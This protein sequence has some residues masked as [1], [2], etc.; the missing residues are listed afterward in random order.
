MKKALKENKKIKVK[1]DEILF[2][3]IQ[4]Q[5]GITFKESD[6][7]LCGDGYI[8]PLRIY[9]LPK[10]L[11]D[12]WLDDIL[13]IDGTIGAIDISTRDTAEVKKNI[14]KSLKEEFTRKHSAKDYLE[15]YDAT[16]R[17]QE[18]EM[19]L[20]ELSE[21]GETVKM[22]DFRLFIP[23]RRQVEME[24]RAEVIVK[25][26]EGDSYMCS[27]F[28]NEGRR[29][30]EA[31]F[32]P[33][34]KSHAKTFS[35]KGFP[36]LTEQLAYGDPFN[37]SEL[38]DS[39]GDLIGFTS[40]DGAVIFDEFTK[41]ETRKHYNS[42]VVGD[43]GSGK[44]TLLKKRFKS[45]AAKGNFIRTFDI[46][47]EFTEL[48]KEFGGKIIKCNGESGLLN[49]ME[50]L[51]AGDD[52]ATS[53]ARHISKVSTF[54]KAIFPSA[55]DELISSLQNV[56]R[57]F[58]E[59][60]DLLPGRLGGITSL[61]SKS[62]PILSDLLH[63][64]ESEMDNILKAP[65]ETV[66]EKTL[67]EAKIK[68]LYNIENAIKNVV[69]NYGR[70]FDGHTSVDN[71]TDEKIV[72]FDISEIKDL[73]NVFA[74][75]IFNMVSLCWDNAVSNGKIMK[76][77]WEEETAE[78][79][80]IVK[81]LIIIDESHRWVNTKMP[82]ILDLL[83]K[84]LREARK[85][86]AGIIF[87]S[88]SMRDYIP[89]G[90]DAPNVDLIKVL[91][92]LTQYKFI[93]RQDSSTVPLLNAVFNNALTYSQ[94]EKIPF[95]GVGENILCISGDSSLHFKVWLSQNYEAKLFKGGK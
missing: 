37:Y 9:Q 93:F 23:E 88:Q 75:Q 25:N 42:L 69:Q 76:E 63:F 32:E 56:L 45:N 64:I 1:E 50:I 79:E 19:L 58:Y 51:K 82:M 36:L 41:T 20:N 90:L 39:R 3:Y 7:I 46:T 29:E 86:F 16:I 8:K 92:E 60:Y 5:G 91:F 71:I 13:N 54:F 48:T 95:L 27:C 40:T 35:M 89:E 94:I 2:N 31:I 66:A 77:L 65:T 70:M 55:T 18:L 10:K 81:F 80:D 44:S 67:I 83:I 53:Y 62:Y 47:G 57:D 15:L 12:F 26:L 22:T 52:D 68:D 6:Y 21:M 28:L 11:K 14:N 30:W 72:T 33:Y 73:G 17:Q 84:Y 34:K 24:D 49:P 74:A 38:I 43:M 78:D 85:Y 59:S 61:P 87:A 4:P